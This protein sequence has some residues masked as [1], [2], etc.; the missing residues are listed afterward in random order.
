M[1]IYDVAIIGA[2]PAGVHAAKWIAKKGMKVLLIEK[3]KDISHITRYCSEHFI[4]EDGYNGD[5]IIM[6][7]EK[8]KLISTVFGWEVNYDGELCP[9]TDK[10]YYSPSGHIVHFAWPDRRPFAY[11]FDKGYLLKSILDEALALGITY[12]NETVA[13]D[14]LDT[15]SGVEIKLVSK[16]KKDKV[17]AK[18]LIV[19]DGCITSLGE[20]L[21]FNEDRVYLGETLVMAT[22]MSG[23]ETYDPKD[24]KFYYG[25]IYGSNLTPITGT[26]PA[27]HFDWMD[28][29]NMGSAALNPQDSFDYFKRRSPVAPN[30]KNAKIEEQYCCTVKVFTPIKKPYKGNCIL[31][32]DSA[33][34]VQVQTQGALTCGYLAADAI[35]K[36]FNG[37]K[38]FEEYTEKWMNSFEFNREGM[39]EE[40]Q[41][42]GF[43]PR[44][45]DEEIDYLFSLCE[46]ILLEGNFSQYKTARLV[47]D[48]ILKDPEKIEKERPEIYKKIASTPAG[49]LSDSLV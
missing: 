43:V 17:K 30:F 40:S 33:A 37:Q 44:Y 4:L 42:Y 48:T 12:Q 36:E 34:F 27:G 11:K 16:G 2:G 8:N 18:K 39:F 49:S 24:S 20:A 22:Y 7:T 38:G 25:R 15:G 14:A 10:M 6:D 3:R 19:A 41:A 1:N 29:V 32:G 13:Y 26:G 21:G 31:I 28:V 9:T 45:E 5:T 46:G 35:E 47:W 23:V